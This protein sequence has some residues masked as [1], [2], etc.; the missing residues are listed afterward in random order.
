M[1]ASRLAVVTGGAGFIG[2]HLVERLLADGW[3]V[4]AI[5][6]GSVGRPQNLAHLANNAALNVV[7]ADVADNAKIAPYFAG[8]ERVF[9]L[10]A[11]ADIVPSIERPTDYFR[12]NVV[13]TE[14]VLE[15]ARAAKVKR[16]VYAAS[17]SCYGIPDKYP[18]P[19]TAPIQPQYPYALTKRLGEELVLHW[20]QVYGM[21][22]V[23]TRF[24]NVY[25]PR[26]RTSGTYGAVFGVFL[27]QKIHGKPFT[28]V[29]DGQQTRD[30]T[31]VTDVAAALVA[32]ADSAAIGEIFNVGS[33]NT[34]SVNR[35]VELL[36]GPVTYIPKRPGEPDCTFADISKIRCVLGWEPKIPLEE[37]VKR[38][39]ERLDD[40]K[41]APVWTPQSIEL[42]TKAWFDNLTPAS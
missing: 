36:G 25:G 1:S 12:S 34:Y 26:A 40:W 17:S 21:P 8:A 15:A 6:N 2:S 10:A 42:A 3:H 13:G 28:V 33:G 29:G 14:S 22:V 23:S 31:Y 19:E 35:L 24:F 39:L 9:H 5:D 32:A 18:T 30:F 7:W 20:G 27:A 4:T 11:L 16:F 38:M 41:S 37:G